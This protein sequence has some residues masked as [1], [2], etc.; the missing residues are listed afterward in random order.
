MSGEVLTWGLGDH[1]QLGLG[2]VS[3]VLVP[4][5]V[6]ETSNVANSVHAVSCGAYHCLCVTYKGRILAWGAG[7]FGQLGNGRTADAYRPQVLPDWVGSSCQIYCGPFHN[8]LTAGDGA[9]LFSWGRGDS[10]QLGYKARIQPVPARVPYIFTK[11]DNG[12]SAKTV[13]SA[14]CGMNHSAIVTSDGSVYTWG[15]KGDGQLGHGKVPS[16]PPA[17]PL[18]GTVDPTT[19]RIR[20]Q[21]ISHRNRLHT[22]LLGDSLS[23]LLSSAAQKTTQATAAKSRGPLDLQKRYHKSQVPSYNFIRSPSPYGSPPRPRS[24]TGHTRPPRPRSVTEQHRHRAPGSA[25]AQT[26]RPE[27]ALA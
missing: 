12:S 18:I 23:P 7:G 15:A 11:P 24:V 25:P 9:E 20:L 6:N 21:D 5:I 17:G 8:L 26:P 14:A 16:M 10:G 3:R 2:E 4:T 13:V 27:S 19:Q 22:E 1:G